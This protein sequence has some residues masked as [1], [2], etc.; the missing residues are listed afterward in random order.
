MLELPFVLGNEILS[1]SMRVLGLG[2]LQPIVQV[3]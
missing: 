3:D 2:L 1:L